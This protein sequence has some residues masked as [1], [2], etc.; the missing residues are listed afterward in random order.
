LAG[1]VWV[2]RSHCPFFWQQL[3]SAFSAVGNIKNWGQEMQPPQSSVA[4]MRRDSIELAN[5]CST[6]LDFRIPVER[7]S[8]GGI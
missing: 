4:T 8:D 2:G 1:A 3:F 6:T 5:T 7:G